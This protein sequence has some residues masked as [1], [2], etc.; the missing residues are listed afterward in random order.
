[1]DTAKKELNEET[2]RFNSIKSAIESGALK[3]GLSR[4]AVSSQYGEPVVVNEDRATNRERWV[5]KPASS[6]F[7]EGAKAYLFFDK[8]GALDEIK[9]TF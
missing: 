4:Q 6:S 9:L 5:Y 8:N 3:K 1:M 2:V 7:F